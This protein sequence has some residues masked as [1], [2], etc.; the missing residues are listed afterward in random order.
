MLTLIDGMVLALDVIT[1]DG[2]LLIAR[3]YQ[4]NKTMRERLRGVAVKPGVKEPI[5]VRVPLLNG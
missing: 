1:V 4:V 5:E 2:R 3:G